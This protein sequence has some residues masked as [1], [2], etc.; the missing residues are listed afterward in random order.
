MLTGKKKY[1][2][3]KIDELNKVKNCVDEESGAILRSL[4]K[5]ILDDGIKMYEVMKKNVKR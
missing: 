3:D 4:C 2:Q 1:Y 5:Q